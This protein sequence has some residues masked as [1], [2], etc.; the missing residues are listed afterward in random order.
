[1]KLLIH[2]WRPNDQE[3]L[4]YSCTSGLGWSS[5]QLSQELQSGLWTLLCRI[6]PIKT[7]ETNVIYAYRAGTEYM[8]LFK[9]CHDC[10]TSTWSE[11]IAQ[12]VTIIYQKERLPPEIK[13]TWNVIAWKENTWIIVETV[14]WPWARISY[15]FLFSYFYFLPGLSDE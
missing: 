10:F 4:H 1:M 7:Q 8:I 11:I 6:Q 13:T 9:P 3:H 15:L 14:F 5:H 2:P 12:S